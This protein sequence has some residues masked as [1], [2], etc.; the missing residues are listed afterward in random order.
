MTKETRTYKDRAR[1]NIEAVTKRR[2]KLKLMAVALKGGR[3]QFCGYNRY[4]GAL[5]FH[6]VNE[7]IKKFDLSTRGLTRSWEKIKKEIEKCVLVCSNCHREIHGGII[8]LPHP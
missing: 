7:R 4:I 8:K 2:K 6:H 3:C 1:Y 5:D